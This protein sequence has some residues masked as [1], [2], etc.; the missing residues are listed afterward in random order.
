MQHALHG[1]WQV[2]A[3][4]EALLKLREAAEHTAQVHAEE[5]QAYMEA[6]ASWA[7]TD[8]SVGA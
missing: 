6:R 2:A 8:N 1:T 5:V 7:S 4:Q 3:V